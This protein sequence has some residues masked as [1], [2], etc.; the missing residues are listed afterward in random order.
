VHVFLDR[1]QRGVVVFAARD[2]EELVGIG[3]PGL[4]FE[5][6]LHD[7]VE[8]LLFTAQVLGALGV[9][10]HVRRLEGA[11][12]FD[13]AGSLDIEVKDTP[14]ARGPDCEDR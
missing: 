5:D 12:D 7:A 13:Q 3:Q 10:P 8:Q 9:F 14:V 1:H 11:V 6:A 4:E 2:L